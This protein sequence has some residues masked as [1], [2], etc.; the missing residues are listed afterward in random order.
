MVIAAS[1]EQQLSFITQD[2]PV[3]RGVRRVRVYVTLEPTAYRANAL[4]IGGYSS[5]EAIVNL[6]LL[7]GAR[8]LASDRISLGHAFVVW[9]GDSHVGATRPVTLQCEFT[10]PAPDDET[11]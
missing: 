11:T 8:V 5:A 1:S 6:R 10:R 9:I 3:G 2:L 7:E 4:N